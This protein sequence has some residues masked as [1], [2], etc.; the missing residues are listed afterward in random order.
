MPDASSSNCAL[1]R[2]TVISESEK[3]GL[4]DDVKVYETGCMG[5]CAVGPVMLVLPDRIF[6]TELTEQ[7]VKDIVQSHLVNGKMI[8]QYTFY[9]HS[10]EKHVPV[11]DDI[12][13][14]KKQV[15]IALR[16]CGSIEYGDV[17]AYIA[18][19]GYFAAYKALNELTPQA[20]VDEVKKSGL[21]GRGGAG[22]P[23][24]I[25]WEAGL[26]QKSDKKYIVCNADEGDPG[27]FMDRSIIEGDPHTVIEGMLIGGYAIGAHLG[28]IYIRAE[29]PIAVKRM[30]AALEEARSCGDF[31]RKYI[32]Q[33]I[34]LRSGNTYRRGCIC[35]R[36]GDGTDVVDR[37][38]AR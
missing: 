9:D 28:Y 24:G 34:F 35:L 3:A 21:K 19:D 13:F 38:K 17:N 22:F 2:D 4:K 37:G 33:R 1:I 7:K 25:K 20:V 32:R 5:T 8:E 16:N 15:K 31:G 12:N 36:R 27:A 30:T 11:I 18:S 29:Y 14:F 26:K 6:Y 10:L 23:T